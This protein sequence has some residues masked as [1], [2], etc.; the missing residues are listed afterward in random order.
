MRPS[1]SATTPHANPSSQNIRSRRRLPLTIAAVIAACTLA[2]A[3]DAAFRMGSMGGS[4]GP[5]RGIGASK[6]TPVGTGRTLTAT[7]ISN[8]AISGVGNG[9]GTGGKGTGDGGRVSTG[10]GGKG[11]DGHPRRPPHWK[12]PIITVIPPLLTAT[13]PALAGGNSGGSSG[14]S[15]GGSPTGPQSPSRA[16]TT[17]AATDHVPDE[18]LTQFATILSAE[19]VEALGRRQGLERLESFDA[20]GVTMTR[21]RIPDRRSVPT[22]I[23]SLRSESIV[24]AVQ[25]NFL[26]QARQAPGDQ[27][28]AAAASAPQPGGLGEQYASAKLRLAQAHELATGEKVLVAVID[29]GIDASHPELAGAIAESFDALG[30]EEKVHAH[31]TAVAGAIVAHA[32]LTGAAPQ[33]R[34]LAARAFDAKDR[35]AEATTYTIDKA[36]DW[37]VSRGARIVNMSFTG[38]RDPA[39][40]QRLA[41]AAKQGIILIAAAGNDGPKAPAA[42]PAAYPGVIAVTATDIDDKLFKNANRGSHIAVAAPGVDLLLPAPADGYQMTTGTSFAAAEVS[43]IAALML[44]R[45]PDLGPDGVRKALMATARVLGPRPKNGVDPQFGAGLVDAYAAI[46]A[47]E[48]AVA[49]AGPAARAQ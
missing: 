36:L 1:T 9:R 6:M 21:W 16:S 18:V 15:S 4:M 20:N 12:P 30:S 11:G 49:R 32:Q 34:I 29:S 44:E 26:Y 7:G 14:N 24:L 10:D 8:Q 48:P 45:K 23:R 35:A 5:A 47:L 43:G 3:A 46:R 22:V 41:K 40:E 2:T 39:M 27:P 13:A 25:P 17:G 33:A 38:P 37:A 31:G 42:Y 28:A 19:T